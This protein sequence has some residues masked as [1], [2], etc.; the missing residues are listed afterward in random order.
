ML[1]LLFFCRSTCA[2]R[3]ELGSKHRIAMRRSS[4]E[5]VYRERER[6]REKERERHKDNRLV[7]RSWTGE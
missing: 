1:L 4:P 6:E 5:R 2:T 7:K 3:R